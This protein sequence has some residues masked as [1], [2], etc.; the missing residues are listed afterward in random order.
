MG[1]YFI[2]F[3]QRLQSNTLTNTLFYVFVPVDRGELIRLEL[4]PVLVNIPR[5]RKK[6]TLIT[7]NNEASDGYGRDAACEILEIVDEILYAILLWKGAF[8]NQLKTKLTLLISP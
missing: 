8:S 7:T 3:I 5:E 6:T 1:L 4:E 2:L